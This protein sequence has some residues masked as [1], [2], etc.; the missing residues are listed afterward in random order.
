MTKRKINYPMGSVSN[1]TMRPED[2]I[3]AFCGELNFRLGVDTWIPSNTRKRHAE[4]IREIE[5]HVKTYDT[6]EHDEVID[7]L[8]ALF[9][10]L[11]E[12]AGPYFYFG[13]HPGDGSD[14]GYWLGENWDEDFISVRTMHTVESTNHLYDRLKVSDLS[15]VPAKF[16]GEVAVVN[17]HGNINLYVKSA[18]KLT[19][20]WSVV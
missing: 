18:R 3:P 20:I 6:Y 10:A 17:D 5:D 9:D 11:D 8:D 7:D 4:L 15:E 1:G 13:A 2:L 12:Y 19:E 14:Y 16:R